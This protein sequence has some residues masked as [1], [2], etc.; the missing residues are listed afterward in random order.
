[1]GL[2]LCYS[3]LMA[4]RRA[5]RQSA[6]WILYDAVFVLVAV[7][8]FLGCSVMTIGGQWRLFALIAYSL[9]WALFTVSVGKALGRRLHAVMAG[10]A[11]RIQ[12]VVRHVNEKLEKTE[13]NE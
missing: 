8:G 4:L 13:E 5:T 6:L 11:R 7:L 1:M 2:G 3:L 9:A 10:A 12:R